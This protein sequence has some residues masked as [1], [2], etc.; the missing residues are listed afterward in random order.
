MAISDDDWDRIKSKWANKTPEFKAEIK[1]DK[2]FKVD[3]QRGHEGEHSFFMK[4]QHCITRLDGKGADFEI[5]KTSETIELKTDYFDFNKTPNF[6]MEKYSY[7]DNLGGPW[8][9]LEHKIEYFIYWY[10]SSGDTFIFNTVQLVK[11]LKKLEAN[12]PMVNVKNK[13][14]V[15]KG[16]KV[17]RDLL[18]DI[19]LAPEDIG[20]FEFKGKK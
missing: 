6:F 5:N 16:Y 2:I 13:N 19:C 12:L 10:P 14:Y 15:T 3:L 7:G 8:R 4:Y 9:S 11:K 18:M 20:L 1:K 17:N